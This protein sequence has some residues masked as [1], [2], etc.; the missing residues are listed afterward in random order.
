MIKTEVRDVLKRIWQ[1]VERFLA[2]W[3]C[4]VIVAQVLY[5]QPS[6]TPMGD[7]LF[8][9]TLFADRVMGVVCLLTLSVLWYQYNKISALYDDEM[10]ETLFA[11]ENPLL[12]FPRLDALSPSA[13][14]A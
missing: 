14:K 12:D 4:H 7:S 10:R 2:M 11:D 3:L 13:I 1:Y 5:W 8:A 9:D 6:R